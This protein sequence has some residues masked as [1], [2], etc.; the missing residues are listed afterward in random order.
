VVKADVK[1]GSGISG[2]EFPNR[3]L[4]SA[5]A[6][7]AVREY[8]AG[9]DEEASRRLETDRRS[10]SSTDPAAEWTCAPGGPALIRR[11]A[12]VRFVES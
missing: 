4:D 9:V 1:R 11:M 2:A 8:L 5:Q 12:T 7:R 10:I 3:K 6:A